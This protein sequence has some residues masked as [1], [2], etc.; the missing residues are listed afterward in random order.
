MQQQYCVTGALYCIVLHCIALYC[1]ENLLFSCSRN[2][3]QWMAPESLLLFYNS[4]TLALFWAREVQS[5]P[6]CP[7]SLR[8]G[9]VL[10]S[11][12]SQSVPIDIFH[13]GFSTQ[14]LYSF[15]LSLLYSTRHVHPI[16][17][18]NTPVFMENNCQI[19]V[20]IGVGK[21]EDLLQ[22]SL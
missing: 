18:L 7:I 8:P 14:I 2:V 9:S 16:I 12:I 1:L 13:A 21:I 6:C 11:Y 20:Y 22:V 10:S 15:P 17:C 19:Q 3:L 5:T 4:Q